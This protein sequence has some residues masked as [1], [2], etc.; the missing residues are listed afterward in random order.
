LD[1]FLDPVGPSLKVTRKIYRGHTEGHKDQVRHNKCA[2][3]TK[4]LY[5]A[6]TA[7]SVTVCMSLTCTVIEIFSTSSRRNSYRKGF[8]ESGLSV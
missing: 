2:R 7:A 6:D 1:L 3:E 5:P 4:D 8:E